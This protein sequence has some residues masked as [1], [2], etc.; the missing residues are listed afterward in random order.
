MTKFSY[1]PQADRNDK[2]IFRETLGSFGTTTAPGEDQLK[3]LQSKVRQGVKHV[4][5][6]LGNQGKGEFNRQDVPDKYGFEQ[7]RTIMQLAKLNKQTLSVHGTFNINSFAGISR[8]GLSD[9]ER[10]KSIK[11]ID[12]TL[13]FAAETAK[14]GAVVFHLHETNLPTP[15]GELNLPKHYLEWLKN[16]KDP[17]LRAEYERIKEDYLVQNPLKRKFVDDPT[18]RAN[19]RVEYQTM[20]PLKRK[21]FEESY[22]SEI[23]EAKKK[24]EEAWDVFYQKERMNQMKLS[25]ELSPLVLMGGKIEQVQRDRETL[26]VA[27]LTGKFTEDDDSYDRAKAL[28]DKERN[29]L[30]ELGV[31]VEKL[32][33]QDYQKAMAIFT[34]DIPREARDKITRE[35]FT[36]LKKKLLLRYDDILSENEYMQSEADAKMFKKQIQENLTLLGLQKKNLEV[37]YEMYKDDLNRIKI[38]EK[39]NRDSLSAIEKLGT[40]DVDKAAREVIKLDIAKRNEEIQKL[41]YQGIGI[42]EYQELARYDE[43]IAQLNRQKKEFEEKK[44]GI[45]SL[46]EEVFTRNASAMGDLGLRALK[47]QLDLKKSSK[48]SPKLVAEYRVKIKEL[49]EKRAKSS[50]QDDYDKLTNEINKLKY[51]QRLHVGRSDYDDIDVENKPLYLAP[52]N[53]MAGYGYMDSLEEYKGVIRESWNQFAHKLLSDDPSYKDIRDAYEKETGKKVTSFDDAVKIAKHHIGGTFDNA[54]AGVWLKFFRKKEGESEETRL[55]EFNKWLNTEAEKMYEEGIIKHV[56]FNDTQGKDD[57]HNLLGSGL[58]DIHDLRERLRKKG[59]NEAWIVEAGGRG[60]NEVMHIMNAFD[61]FN[62][63]V[64]RYKADTQ[65][66]ETSSVSDWLNVKRTYQNRPQY[67]F[68]GLGYSAFRPQQSQNGNHRG[69]WSGMN[70][71]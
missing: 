10:W 17:K 1:A 36:T 55:R 29:K 9:W 62:P 25:P 40:D 71:L 50:K 41:Q 67:S 39:E 34:N 26:N 45:K 69:D 6:H 4:E 8:S 22:A 11:E 48:E 31:D 58:L 21:R 20:D 54:H 16:N 32:T 23:V 35:E 65:S 38:L 13:K 19:A 15:A 3:Q 70:F 56:H 2:K 37:K 7:R 66:G 47:Y 59:F 28:T 18:R 51:E 63:M 14:Q 42:S 53:I 68:Y 57:D 24:G 30:M 46:T 5:L 49:E 33:L 64:S 43:A 52:E 12:E 27:A 44:E 60:A 61:I